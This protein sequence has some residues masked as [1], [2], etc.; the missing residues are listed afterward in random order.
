MRL[1]DQ[2][3]AEEEQ[4]ASGAA[5]CVDVAGDVAVAV[6]DEPGFSCPPSVVAAIVDGAGVV[7]KASA[8]AHEQ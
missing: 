2:V 7:A 5:S 3:A 4:D 6:A 8:L 1:R